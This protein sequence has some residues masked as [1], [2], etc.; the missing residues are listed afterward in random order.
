MSAT[1]RPERE[2]RSAQHEGSPVSATGRPEREGTPLNLSGGGTAMVASGAEVQSAAATRAVDRRLTD[3]L[4]E[5]PAQ[6]RSGPHRGAVAGL[7]DADGRAAYA[8]PEITGYYLQWIAWQAK[9]HGRSEPLAARA[10]AAQDWLG[11][12]LAD[13]PLP[14][15]RV[16]LGSDQPDWRN[17]AV[18]TFDTAM[19]LRGIAS[20]ARAGLLRPA[21]SVVQG[22]G[23]LLGL[24]VGSDGVFD[25]C[26]A[27]TGADRLPD[28]WSTRRGSFL[29]KAA[30]GVIAAAEIVPGVVASV[31]EAA[32]CTLAASLR[33][34]DER[35][36]REV[37]PLLYAAEGFLSLPA[38]RLLPAALP[39]I[40]RQFAE[41]LRQSRVPGRVPEY[42]DAEPALAGAE[43]L[44]IVAQTLRVAALLAANGVQESG[45]APELLH[46][47]QRL[48][49]SM[50]PQGTLPFVAGE[51]PIRHNVWATM[52]ADQ[53]L[54][55]VGADGAVAKAEGDATLVV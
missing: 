9:R 35:P 24:L 12:W 25:A 39:I 32:E 31:V 19:A 30:A 7:V 4:L 11:R 44:D 3:W 8:Y 50:T 15:T 52:F 33:W 2:C 18:F 5:G 47:R 14:R 36:H 13:A 6:L 22:L 10:A 29:A 16:F 42:L 51:L 48:V 54:A 1:G 49:A 46:L 20:A 21:G 43:R 23:R 53:A 38:H 40:G 41:L 28:R 45:A 37:H 17:D 34:L 55:F 26:A 27:R